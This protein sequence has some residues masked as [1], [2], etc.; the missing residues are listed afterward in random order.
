VVLA[1]ATAGIFQMAV[2]PA[3]GQFHHYSYDFTPGTWQ[4][5]DGVNFRVATAT[6]IF[7]VLSTMNQFGINADQQSGSD[8][9]RLDNVALVPEPASLSAISLGLLI[10]AKR[11][12][13]H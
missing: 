9:T 12:R 7:T 11:R 8:Y 4:Y 5:S 10:L 6:D 3:D 1:N 13:K 2:V